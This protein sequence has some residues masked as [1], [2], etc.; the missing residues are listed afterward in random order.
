MVYRMFLDD[1]GMR[2]Y[3]SNNA[4]NLYCTIRNMVNP[5]SSYEY[6]T[7]RISAMILNNDRW[8]EPFTMTTKA[9]TFKTLG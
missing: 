7:K 1:N 5:I 6:A 4:T 9:I 8:E 2:F 3:T